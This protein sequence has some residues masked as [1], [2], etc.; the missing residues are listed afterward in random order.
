MASLVEY[1]E[2]IGCLE[3]IRKRLDNQVKSV[4]DAMEKT[5]RAALTTS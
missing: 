1:L 3:G 2:E 5:I 4:K